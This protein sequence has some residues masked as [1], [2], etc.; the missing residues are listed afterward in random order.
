MPI[1]IGLTKTVTNSMCSTIFHC[2]LNAKSMYWFWVKRAILKVTTF[3]INSVGS[4]LFSLWSSL[5][6]HKG[7]NFK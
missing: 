5:S 6:E 4:F 7:E 2:K 3:P 1:W